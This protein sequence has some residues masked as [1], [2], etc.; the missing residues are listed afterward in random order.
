MKD[1]TKNRWKFVLIPALIVIA[2]IVLYIVHGGFNFD[3]EFM[4]GI[5]MQINMHTDFNNKEV[6]DLIQEKTVDTVSAKVQTG[7]NP[8]VAVIKTPPVDETVK[9]EIF[10]ALKDK[11]NLSDDDLL[12]V[13]SASASFGNEIQR[14]A[15][16]YTLLA[17]ICILIYIAIRFEWRSA[18]MAVIALAINVL[19]MAAI[20]AITNIP[21]N[22]NFIAAMLT[23][24]GYSINNTIVIFDRIRENLG[25]MK[26]SDIDGVVNKS[27]NQTLMRSLMTSVTTLI[28][29]IPLYIMAGSVIREFALPLMI[30]V[31]VGCISSVMLCSPLYRDL[32][33]LTSGKKYRGA[34][35]KTAK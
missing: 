19:I 12:S 29:M 24:V 35:A 11:Y 1:L 21:L 34:K 25:M 8:Q 31:I 6:A 2:G 28:V 23:V 27:V 20:Y 16:L 32:C 4:G 18:I 9:T 17:I 10:N 5:R 30:G 14:K 3:V 33:V 7:D 26:K 15:L 22:T 13:S